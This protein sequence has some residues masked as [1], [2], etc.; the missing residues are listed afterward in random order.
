MEFEWLEAKRIAVL[1]ARGLDFVRGQQLF[2]GRQIYTVASPRGLEQRWVSIGEL[3]DRLVAVVWTVR[4]RNV[5][6]ITMR[7]ARRAEERRYRA[8]HG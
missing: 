6:I 1:K 2:D 4:G 8:L 3:N 7:R 5:R